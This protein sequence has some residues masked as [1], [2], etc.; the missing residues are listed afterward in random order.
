MPLKH[1]ILI[2]SS[3]PASALSFTM[4]ACIS[5]ID[6]YF[7]F[8]WSRQVISVALNCGKA[9]HVVL[10][11]VACSF[12]KK[13]WMLLFSLF[14]TC[15]RSLDRLPWNDSTFVK[16]CFSPL[17]LIFVLILARSHTITVYFTVLLYFCL[18]E[19]HFFRVVLCLNWNFSFYFYLRKKICF[20]LAVHTCEHSLYSI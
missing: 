15:S 2:Y 19:I 1:R 3:G 4:N 12:V 18:V 13:L 9:Q 7:H 16:G 6:I 14:L 11:S 5:E 20:A 8:E 17:F 10:S